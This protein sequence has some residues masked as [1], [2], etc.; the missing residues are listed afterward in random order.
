MTENS[1]P[2]YSP[3]EI[4]RTK[5]IAALLG[6][7]SVTLWSLYSNNA[8]QW[9]VFLPFFALFGLP[10]AFLSIWLVGDPFIRRVMRRPLSWLSSAWAGA[11]IAAILAA[12]SIVIGRLHGY[13]IYK[14]PNRLSQLGGGD[15]V[16]SIDGILTP[17]GWLIVAQNS[18]IFILVGAGVGLA[19][20]F[21]IGPGKKII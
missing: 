17:Y 16:Q 7:A 19:L 6:W 3:K 18:A 13:S 11:G 10:I 14:D 15:Y 20:R 4:R 9:V 2:A 21:M 12:I 1:P 8:S 5:T